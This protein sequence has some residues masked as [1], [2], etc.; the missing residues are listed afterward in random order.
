MI[1]NNCRSPLKYNVIVLHLYYIFL[2]AKV[3][4]SFQYN[5]LFK[6]V[7]YFIVLSA[8]V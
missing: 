7:V 2:K 4:V 3:Q 8:T 5:D 1:L 6:E